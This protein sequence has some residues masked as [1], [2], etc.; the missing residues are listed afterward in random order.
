MEESNDI[1]RL[2]LARALTPMVDGEEYW[3]TYHAKHDQFRR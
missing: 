2:G 1:E 3:K